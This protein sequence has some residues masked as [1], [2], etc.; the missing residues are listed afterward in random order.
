MKPIVVV[1]DKVKLG[2]AYAVFV[3]YAVIA[4]ALPAQTFTTLHSFDG[5]GGVSPWAMAFVRYDQ[6]E[7]AH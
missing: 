5:T 1:L 4:A 3:V 7:V 6:V 2:S